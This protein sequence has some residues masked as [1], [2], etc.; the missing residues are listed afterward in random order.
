[1]ADRAEPVIQVLIRTGFGLEVG[2][3]PCCFVRSADPAVAYGFAILHLHAKE[4][5]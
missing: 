1:M 4:R 5:F 3:L 2:W